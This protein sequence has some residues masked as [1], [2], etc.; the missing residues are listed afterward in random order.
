MNCPEFAFVRVRLGKGIND[1]LLKARALGNARLTREQLQ[2]AT[3]KPPFFTA[4]YLCKVL[5]IAD[6]CGEGRTLDRDGAAQE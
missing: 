3:W 2:F 1:F 4:A 5:E 6:H